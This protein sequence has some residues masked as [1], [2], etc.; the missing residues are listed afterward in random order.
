MG[1]GCSADP[2]T[3]RVEAW[4]WPGD[5]RVLMAALQGG[6]ERRLLMSDADERG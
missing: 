6:R 2:A 4:Q 3:A 5:D 1:G